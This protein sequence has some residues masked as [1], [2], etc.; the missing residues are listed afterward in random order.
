[1]HSLLHAPLHAPEQMSFMSWNCLYCQ[2][3]SSA[4]I[5]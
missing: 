4:F 1:M 2:F 3:F 5:F